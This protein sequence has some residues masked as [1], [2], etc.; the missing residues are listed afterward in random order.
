[1]G[2]ELSE[3][4]RLDG[5]LEVFQRRHVGAANPARFTMGFPGSRE[6]RPPANILFQLLHIRR[7]SFCACSNMAAPSTPRCSMSDFQVSSNGVVKVIISSA[8]GRVVE[9]KSP[10]NPPF[11]RN[12]PCPRV[13][14]HRAPR[15]LHA[16]SL[17]QHDRQ[18]TS[19]MIVRQAFIAIAGS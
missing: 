8:N 16:K 19:F 6:A 2:R 10:D 9:L 18:W 7:L 3:E 11:R 4:L 17:G 12:V 1:M 5:L 15:R 13:R 14:A